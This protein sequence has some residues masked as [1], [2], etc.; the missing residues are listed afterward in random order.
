MT[1]RTLGCLQEQLRATATTLEAT[2]VASNSLSIPM[3]TSRAR[4]ETLLE[5]VFIG[6]WKAAQRPFRQLAN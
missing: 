1:N 3:R 4:F 6:S 5:F 2:T